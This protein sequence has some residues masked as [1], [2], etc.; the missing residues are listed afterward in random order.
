MRAGLTECSA[1]RV[2]KWLGND[3]PEK[4]G[5]EALPGLRPGRGGIVNFDSYNR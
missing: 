5:W 2:F 4:I 3:S 1:D